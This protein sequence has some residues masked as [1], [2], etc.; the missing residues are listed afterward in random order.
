[1]RTP[2]NPPFPITPISTILTPNER[3]RVDEAGDQSRPG[4]RRPPRAGARRSS[5]RRR[6][7]RAGAR[8]VGDEFTCKC[9]AQLVVPPVKE[10]PT[11]RPAEVTLRIRELRT[12]HRLSMVSMLVAFA[13]C[14]ALL[15]GALYLLVTERSYVSGTCAVIAALAFLVLAVIATNEWRRTSAELAAE[16][17]EDLP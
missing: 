10:A 1:M 5:T 9:G 17:V 11:T 6:R 15:S 12:R 16:D 13:S 14:I 8:R 2:V 4:G 3:L 7:P